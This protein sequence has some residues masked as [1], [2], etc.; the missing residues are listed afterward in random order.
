MLVITSLAGRH[1]VFKISRSTRLEKRR[2]KFVFLYWG[3]IL[4]VYFSLVSACARWCIFNNRSR[5]WILS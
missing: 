3:I 5:A 4:Q 1:I 2:V